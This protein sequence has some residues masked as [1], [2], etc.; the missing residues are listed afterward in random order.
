MTERAGLLMVSFF[1]GT[2]YWFCLLVGF[3]FLS[4][5]HYKHFCTRELL[6]DVLVSLATLMPYTLSSLSVMETFLTTVTRK[7][8]FSHCG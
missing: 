7:S 1:L 5:C 2:K 4:V 8:K 6:V 3:C